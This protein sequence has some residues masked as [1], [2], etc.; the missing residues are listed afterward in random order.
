MTP[1]AWGLEIPDPLGPFQP[2]PFCDSAILR[3]MF[4]INGF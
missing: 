3:Q 2:G 1:V 4:Q